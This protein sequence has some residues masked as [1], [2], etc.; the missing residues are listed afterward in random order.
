MV[1]GIY[2]TQDISYGLPSSLFWDTIIIPVNMTQGLMF[3]VPTASYCR[4]YT[5]KSTI[6]ASC[7]TIQ[8]NKF[9]L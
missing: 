1:S 7:C 5:L 6:L 9:S 2:Q 8:L 3:A 4:F